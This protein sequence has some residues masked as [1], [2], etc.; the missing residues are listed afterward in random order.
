MDKPLSAY[1][2]RQI[3]GKL[4]EQGVVHLDEQTISRAFSGCVA[5][6]KLTALALDLWRNGH[7]R[8]EDLRMM[9]GA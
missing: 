4:I 5:A 1:A 9:E 8:D 2:K 3:V 6:N 7:L